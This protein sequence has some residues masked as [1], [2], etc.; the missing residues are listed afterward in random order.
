[1]VQLSASILL[2]VCLAGG[3]IPIVPAHETANPW[4]LRG[5][6]SGRIPRAGAGLSAR[7]RPWRD[8]ELAPALNSG[9]EGCPASQEGGTVHGL[10]L[11]QSVEAVVV[12]G[13]GVG[14]AEEEDARK[15]EED[16]GG[17]EDCACCCEPMTT[18]GLGECG[19]A[20]ACGICTLRLRQLLNETGCIV[21]QVT[22]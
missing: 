1:M 14:A 22:T 7:N 8:K 3:L 9:G 16:E 17:G 20:V 2:A 5:A 11:E 15:E 19:H 18:V 6:A 12:G 4:R 13:G 21:C 10:E